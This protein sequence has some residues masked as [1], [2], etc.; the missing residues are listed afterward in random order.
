MRCK[1]LS[2][3]LAAGLLLGLL[4]VAAAAQEPVDQRMV[5]AIKAEGL[6]Q[7]EAP[8]LFYTLTDRLGQRLTGSPAH[9]EAARWA[10]ERFKKWGLA[11]PHMEPFEFGRGWSLKSSPSR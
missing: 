9:M 4:L 5:A 10:V 11:N 2:M 6:N 3:T 1:L 7:S 8:D